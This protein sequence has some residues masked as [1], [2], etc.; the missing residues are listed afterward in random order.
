M[1]HKRTIGILGAGKLGTSLGRLFIKA[2]YPVLI[3]GSKSI[4][5]IALT[6]EVL[7]PG[8]TPLTNIEVTK[9]ADIILLALPLSKMKTIPTEYL[10]DKII[11]DA[12][13]YW[14][15]VDGL[16]RIPQ[17]TSI[18]SSEL[19]GKVLNSKHVIKAFNHMGYHDLEYESHSDKPKVIAYASNDLDA[20]ET[21]ET[22]IIDLGFDPLNLGELKEGRILE[23][24][25]ALFGANLMKQDFIKVV[26]KIVEA[27][28]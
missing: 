8:A 1:N 4:E 18:S 12:M 28:D 27:E 22:I 16:T 25:T 21:L 17:D 2:G 9:Q 20:K 24:G 11:I 26:K 15:E 19:V 14:K 23:P 3:A 10:E 5:K 7:V 6:V 13:N